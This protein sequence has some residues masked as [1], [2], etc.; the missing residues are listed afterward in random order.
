MLDTIY[1]HAGLPKTGSSSLQDS[2]HALSQA[3]LLTRVGYPPSNPGLGTG[4]GSALARELIFTNP[5][6]TSTAQLQAFVQD[7]LQAGRPGTPHLLI[8]SEDLCYADVEKFSRLRQV[9]LEHARSVKLLVAVRPLR[10]WWQRRLWNHEA[11]QHL[12]RKAF[13]VPFASR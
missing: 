3:G 8:S 5:A 2:L 4:N 13:A 10:A 6:P 11:V 9:L 1:I 7:I 12:C